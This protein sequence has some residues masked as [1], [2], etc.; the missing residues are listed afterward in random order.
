MRMT[1]CCAHCLGVQAPRRALA[2]R[3]ARDQQAEQIAARQRAEQQVAADNAR[4]AEAAA[5]RA[6]EL[7]RALH[8]RTVQNLF[9]EEDD[10]L[11]DDHPP[12]VEEEAESGSSAQPR[13]APRAAGGARAG[14]RDPPPS[15]GQRRLLF[16]LRFQADHKLALRYKTMLS[17]QH[18]AAQE[19]DHMRQLE[20]VQQR[21][22]SY[23]REGALHPDC[24]GDA[25]VISWRPVL[26]RSLL[27]TGKIM[28]P[29]FRW[30]HACPL[31]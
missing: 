12:E 29:K 16:E 27:G 3:V 22:H 24:A 9:A 25:E 18:A 19:Q 15:H 1:V 13:G 26:F 6:A 8:T 20:A 31:Y 2:G 21:V 14:S 11:Q 17:D 30:D 5:A 4:A 7:Q 10:L 28:I 23:V